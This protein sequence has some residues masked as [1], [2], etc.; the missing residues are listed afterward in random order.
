VIQ[1]VVKFVTVTTGIVLSFIEEDTRCDVLLTTPLDPDIDRSV[2]IDTV[3]CD[4]VE[5]SSLVLKLS[6]TA[7]DRLVAVGESLDIG[8]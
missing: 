4:E 5:L 6:G 7:I 3:M 2:D 8:D 1:V